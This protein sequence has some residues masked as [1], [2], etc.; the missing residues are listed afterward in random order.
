MM[1]VRRLRAAHLNQVIAGSRCAGDLVGPQRL[2]GGERMR[3]EEGV[4]PS[5]HRP[6]DGR[7]PPTGTPQ[8]RE[9]GQEKRPD[10]EIRATTHG[11]LPTKGGPPCKPTE[12]GSQ[13][14][15]SVD[16]KDRPERDFAPP[17]SWG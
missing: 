12:R 10:N 13:E 14:T 4:D 1:P 17:P 7:R 2:P 6:H 5:R 3:G 8:T 9:A 15:I 16:A 11:S